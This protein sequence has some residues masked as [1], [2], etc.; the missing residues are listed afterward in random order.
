M[1]TKIP[2]CNYNMSRDE[3]TRVCEEKEVGVTFKNYLSL[4]KHNG[5]TTEEIYKVL[6][7]I[8]VVFH[9]MVEWY[10][11]LLC[12]LFNK[13]LYTGVVWPLHKEF[14]KNWRNSESST[15]RVLRLTLSC[16]MTA[17]AISGLGLHI[18][19]MTLVIIGRNVSNAHEIFKI[20]AKT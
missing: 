4:E 7:N 6:T 3:I 19:M 18:S 15:K 12:Q 9:Y 14:Q 11:N 20:P 10:R 13:D 1:S 2:G 16:K 5:K 17:S 8:I